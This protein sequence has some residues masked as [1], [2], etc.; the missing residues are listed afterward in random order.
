M[1]W[2]LQDFVPETLLFLFCTTDTEPKEQGP[3][4][5]SHQPERCLSL[6]LG[7]PERP[8]RLG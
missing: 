5:E 8:T 1:W 3:V 4:Q 7:H 6:Q 2:A